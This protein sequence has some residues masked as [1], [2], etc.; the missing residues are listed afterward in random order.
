MTIS[1]NVVSSASNLTITGAGSKR[2]GHDRDTGLI[3]LLGSAAN[4]IYLAQMNMTT[5][6]LSAIG[7]GTI[8]GTTAYAVTSSKGFVITYENTGKVRSYSRI[9]SALTLVNTLDL[10]GSP[11][12]SGL[13][14][15]PHTNFIYLI[16]SESGSSRV[17]SISSSGVL[18]SLCVLTGVIFA[19]SGVNTQPIVFLPNALPIVV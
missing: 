17:L 8:T 19:G 6:A 13:Y 10:G 2:P 18:S 5:R 14:V 3:A 7:N 16:S 11:L 4:T 9:G 12:S 15:S 1:G